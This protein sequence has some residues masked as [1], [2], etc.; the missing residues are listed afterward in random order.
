MSEKTTIE[1]C[2][3]KDCKRNGGGARLEQLITQVSQQKIYNSTSALTN[4]HYHIFD[5]SILYSLGPGRK[6]IS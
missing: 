4:L 5:W 1:V 3:F 2:G 6:A